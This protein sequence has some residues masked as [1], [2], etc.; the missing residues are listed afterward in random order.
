MAGLVGQAFDSRQMQGAD[1][2][3]GTGKMNYQAANIEAPKQRA[4]LADSLGQLVNIGAKAV[5]DYQ[6]AQIDK[7]D[8]RSN[9]IIRKLTPAQRREA[10]E[11]GELLYQDDP[12]AMQQLR[13]KTGRNAAFLVDDE[14][15]MMIKRGD[16]SIDTRQKMEE[17]RHTRLQDTSKQYAE[18][19][20]LNPDDEDYQRGFNADITDRN[21]A[22]YGAHDLFLSD[23]AKKGAMINSRTELGSVLNDPNMLRSE[24][25]A[26]FLPMYIINGLTSGAIASD[27]D[28]IELISKTITDA[29]QKEGGSTFINGIADKKITIAGKET[30]IKDL[31]GHDMFDNFVI[32]ASNN[33]YDLDAKKQEAMSLQINSALNQ[34]DP[35]V[36]MQMLQQ[37]KEANKYLQDGDV[38]TPTRQALIT[39]ETQMQ[40]KVVA[41]NKALAKAAEKRQQSDAKML[42]MDE[43]YAKKEAGDWVSTSYKDMPSN[44][45]TGNFT[46]ADDVNWA[47]RKIAQIDNMNVPEGRKDQMKIALLRNSAPDSAVRNIFG[48]IVTEASQE[49]QAG[50][51]NG[52]LP[53]ETPAM[54]QLRKIYNQSPTI[55]A[56]LYPESMKTFLNLDFMDNMGIDASVILEAERAA[57]KESKEIRFEKD[58]AYADFKNNSQAPELARMPSRLDAAARMVFDHTASVTG[59]T[60][61]AQQQTTKFIQENT[62][63]F[64]N[65]GA[66]GKTV[67]LITKE[68]LMIS[69]DVDSYKIGEQIINTAIDQ[70][71]KTN[72]WSTNGRLMVFQQGDNIVIRNTSGSVS[73]T[74][75]KDL[76]GR[77]Y[78]DMV[79]KQEE[80]Q[81][82]QAIKAAGR[83]NRIVLHQAAR[84]KSIRER[85]K[86]IRER[87]GPYTYI[88]LPLPWGK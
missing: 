40:D 68:A 27:N 54:N 42:V 81:M 64:T 14:I 10:I 1:R 58:R 65:D 88:K 32:R 34:E 13:F 67:G 55:M 80:A 21:I 8:E 49:W 84:R 74:Y 2:L 51:F 12:Y 6:Q 37:L 16:K 63:R 35:A 9:E 41:N 76:M 61:F 15:S 18:E 53:E 24:Q 85:E 66:D 46:Y 17:Y 7:A 78:V 11:K 56:Q 28:A 75:D 22:L 33:E 62:V 3:R 31:M 19:F 82:N 45:T 79:T 57:G 60:D 83:R 38:M 4:S 77:M 43:V 52:K 30:T 44:E 23:Q 72:P 86:R 59:N 69:D 26:N 50:V 20:G 5:G 73:V 48:T 29:A 71:A 36:G 39:A 25:G 70:L 47:N 87:G